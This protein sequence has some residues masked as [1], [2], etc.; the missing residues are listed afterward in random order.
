M[1]SS[2]IKY[3]LVTGST[4]FIGAHI[5]DAL[6]SRGLRVRGATRTAAKGEAMLAARP[7]HAQS[8]DFVEIHDF[9]N[10]GDLRKAVQG[11]DAIVHAASPFRYDIT[12]NEK[13]LILP[14]IS[15]TKAMLEAAAAAAEP[16]V[17]R[18]VLTSS[19]AS[20]VDAGR[21][22]QPRTTYTAADWNPITYEEGAA[23]DA[24]P[25]VAYRASKKFAERAAWDFV[26]ANNKAQEGSSS[27]SSSSSS[28][29]LVTLC[30]P[31]VFGPVVHPV[32]GGVSQLNESNAQLWKVAAGEKPLPV[33]R[34]PFWVDVRD[35]AAAH[36]EAVLRPAAGGKRFTVASPEKFSYA[37]AAAVA[38]EA[39][40]ELKGRVSDE[41]QA[42]NDAHDLDG[43]TAR[44][45]LG[46]EYT[47]FE[48][49]VKDF[50]SQALK[51][52]GA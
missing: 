3:V 49:S 51:M 20:V 27:S 15:G 8:L 42:V 46:I 17:R 41:E 10:P 48:K 4:G 16:P 19:F 9:E 35:L 50:V 22:A 14:A 34:V 40:P 13:E 44:A 2:N 29:D 6:L 5:V 7:Q 28:F 52:P 12:D 21:P 32:P 25:V 38:V 18:V 33:A 47:S 36:A 26:A 39:F 1:S 45:E 24:S 23:P 30:P 31:M 43:E 11:V 37:W